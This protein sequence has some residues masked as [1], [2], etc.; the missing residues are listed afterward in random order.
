MF[1]M[2]AAEQKALEGRHVWLPAPNAISFVF[3]RRGG[4]DFVDGRSKSNKH[5]GKRH[6]RAAEK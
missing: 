5:G 1:A 6:R 4:K 2:D 3:K